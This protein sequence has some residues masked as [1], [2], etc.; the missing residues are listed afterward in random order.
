MEKI[1]T[2]FIIILGLILLFF[3]SN[4]AFAKVRMLDIKLLTTK[5]GWV[6]AEGNFTIEERYPENTVTG[7]FKGKFYESCQVMIG[8]F[9]KPDGSRL[10]PF[11]FRETGPGN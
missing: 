1:R 5:I 4:Y 2:N 6:D 10:Q 9:S 8:E 3:L 7:I 11:K